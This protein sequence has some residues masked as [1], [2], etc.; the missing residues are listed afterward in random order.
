VLCLCVVLSVSPLCLCHR[1]CL[2][3]LCSLFSL[4]LLLEES[5][6]VLVSSISQKVFVLSSRSCGM[7]GRSPLEYN[8]VAT[9]YTRWTRLSPFPA[10]EVCYLVAL[11]ILSAVV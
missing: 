3:R 10:P 1:D 9:L 8:I 4:S 2:S 5:P 7:D 6:A 11:L